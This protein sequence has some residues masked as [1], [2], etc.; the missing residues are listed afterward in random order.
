VGGILGLTFGTALN[1][2]INYLTAQNYVLQGYDNNVVVL[3]NVTFFNYYWP[4]GRL[5]YNNGMLGGSQFIYSSPYYD[6]SRY[7]SLY[8]NL[9]TTYGNPVDN[10]RIA[11]GWATTWFGSN[12]GFITLRFEPML[13]NDGRT[14]Y[15]T[16]LSVGN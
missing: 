13:G 16:T 8:N 10:V 7:N 4:Q 11:G 12:N 9:L 14:H 2:S 5:I 15:Y 6:V 3:T 1:V